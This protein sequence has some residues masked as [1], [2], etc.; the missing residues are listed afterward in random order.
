MLFVSIKN[1]WMMKMLKSELDIIAWYQKYEKE[2]IARIF[3]AAKFTNVPEVISV[4]NVKR[5]YGNSLRTSVS[6]LEQYRRC[7]FAFHMKYGLKLAEEEEF[8]IRALDTGNFMHEVIDEVFAKIEDKDLNIKEISKN[9]LFNIIS[10]II[11]KKLGMSKNY[12]FSS[13]P[14]FIALTKRLKKLF[15]SLLIIL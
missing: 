14:K 1:F 3:R 9:E 11:N 8:K 6:R 10:E 7:P 4:E 13:T 5:L 15:I 2:R 12:I